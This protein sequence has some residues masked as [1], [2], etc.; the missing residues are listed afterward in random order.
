MNPFPPFSA[1]CLMCQVKALYQ[2]WCG[3]WWRSSSSS[4][5]PWTGLIDEPF[6]PFLSG[7]PDVPSGSPVPSVVWMV[8]ALLLFLSHTLD[9]ID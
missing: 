1:D 7:L 5:T 9:R 6:S 8:V 4:L 2:V 3:W